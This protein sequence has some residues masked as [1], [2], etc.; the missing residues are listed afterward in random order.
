[1][2]GQLCG[3]LRCHTSEK[4]IALCCVEKP[5]QTEPQSDLFA[6][7]APA[8]VVRALASEVQWIVV[9]RELPAEVH[10]VEL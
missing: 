10:I 9:S 7:F 4:R 1:M 6:T 2:G 8:D 5:E 3:H